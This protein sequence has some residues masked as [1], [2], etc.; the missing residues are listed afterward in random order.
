MTQ[1][2]SQSNGGWS[3]FKFIRFVVKW[4]TF[5]YNNG[6]FI[7][8]LVSF[9]LWR[10]NLSKT[11]WR[12]CKMTV[13]LY[14]PGRSSASVSER[15]R[16]TVSVSEPLKVSLCYMRIN[17]THRSLHYRLFLW[18]NFNMIF[19]ESTVW[20]KLSIC[21]L[22]P[23][24]LLYSF[25]YFFYG[26]LIN[27]IVY[28]FLTIIYG[29]LCRCETSSVVW[30]WSTGGDTTSMAAEC[31]VCRWSLDGD[32]R[33]VRISIAIGLQW[34]CLWCQWHRVACEVSCRARPYNRMLMINAKC[35]DWLS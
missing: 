26:D 34:L 31:I 8:I 9:S 21:V 33:C 17:K 13:I 27:S 19:Y 30:R 29:L 35:S 6:G 1:F 4:H 23:A 3:A 10:K 15:I 25:V 18:E 32:T 5:V 11:L 28:L 24:Y 14:E 7:W 22:L 20:I 12:I 2:I 16:S